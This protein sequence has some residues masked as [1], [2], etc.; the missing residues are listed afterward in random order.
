MVLD[1]S[2]LERKH[3]L[4]EDTQVLEEYTELWIS[5]HEPG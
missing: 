5:N 2:Y 4:L 3:P 1:I